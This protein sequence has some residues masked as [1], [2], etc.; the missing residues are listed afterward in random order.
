[1]AGFFV[2]SDILAARSA[3]VRGTIERL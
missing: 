1:M 3:E 2:D